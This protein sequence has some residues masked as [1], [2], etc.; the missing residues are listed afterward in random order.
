MKM[1][2]IETEGDDDEI[3]ITPMIDCVFLLVLF[4]MVTWSLAEDAQLTEMKLAQAEVTRKIPR[5]QIDVLS[6]TEDGKF[7]FAG[8]PLANLEELVNQLKAQG[9]ERAKPVAIR[10]DARCPYQ[11]FVQ[12]KNAV[13][14]AGIETI[15]EEIEVKK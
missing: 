7:H 4:F 10:C 15:F 3:D 1:R 14:L 6:I 11:F 9:S 8:K 13:R 12:A 5:D 2:L